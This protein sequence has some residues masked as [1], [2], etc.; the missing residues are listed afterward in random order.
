MAEMAESHPAGSGGKP[1]EE[2]TGASGGAA[3]RETVR[4]EE[5][6][7]MEALPARENLL[8]AYRQIMGNKGTAGVDNM[9]VEQCH[10]P[11]SPA[12][13]SCCT[14]FDT[15]SVPSLSTIFYRRLN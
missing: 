1:Q 15:P 12:I 2:G 6:Q 10:D 4:L 9:T 13:G 8:D 3:R 5:S 14:G 7:M 11:N